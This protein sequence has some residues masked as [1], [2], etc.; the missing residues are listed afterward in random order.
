M[1]GARA[2]VVGGGMAGLCAAR[3]LTVAFDEVILLERD[4]YPDGDAPRPGVPQARHAH[5]LL[6]RGWIELE[7]LF[8]GFQ[9]RLLAAGGQEVDSGMD[10]ATLRPAGWQR[11]APGQRLWLM[12]RDGLE[13]IVRDFV[14]QSPVILRERVR[15]TSLLTSPSSRAGGR[16]QVTG[17]RLRSREGGAAT[18]LPADLV[19]DASGRNSRAI[20][21]LTE[22]GVRAP[23]VETVD[24]FAGYSS[25]WYRRPAPARWPSSYWWKGAWVDPRPP[26]QRRGGVL[27]PIE[28]DR[29]IA[30]LYGYSRGY[31]PMDE[32]GFLQAAAELRSP[33]IATS[34]AHAE[35]LGPVHAHRGLLNRFHHYERMPDTVDGFTAIGDSV[36]VFNPIYG[37]GMSVLALCA[38]QLRDVASRLGPRDPALGRTFFAEQARLFQAPWELAT[39]ADFRFPATEG[40]RPRGIALANAYTDALFAAALHDP[41]LLA[42]AGRVF[43]LMQPS[44]TLLKPSRIARVVAG[45]V[46]TRLRGG[47]ASVRYG[48]P[49]PA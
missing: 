27:F 18:E 43:S 14:R 15:A 5:A 36:C 34:L 10:L 42:D 12:S 29:W 16:V 6:E 25:R 33:V 1:S 30:T 45:S 20:T 3:A 4:A 26:G 22:L 17:V 7:R 48:M 9:A 40:A 47:H 24:S 28:G 44:T 21:W 49:P 46:L 19:V 37:Q 39:G 23:E 13:R 31:P 38:V 32:V 35:P 2:V 8:P 11:R 41:V